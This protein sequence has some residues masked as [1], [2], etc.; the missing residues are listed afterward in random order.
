MSKIKMLDK[1]TR[2][3]WFKNETIENEMKLINNA[4]NFIHSL[5]CKFVFCTSFIKFSNTS[6]C[7]KNGQLKH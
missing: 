2:L 4:Q 6:K 7:Y 1:Y 3:Q 5:L